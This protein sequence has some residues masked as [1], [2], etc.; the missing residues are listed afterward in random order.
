MVVLGLG[1]GATVKSGNHS[2]PPDG[3]AGG[4]SP[5]ASGG[6][7]SGGVT[8][9]GGAT[10]HGGALAAAG[11]PTADEAGAPATSEGGAG[12]GNPCAGVAA[13]CT[14]GEAVCDPR[15]G[16]LTACSE[17]GVPAPGADGPDCVRLLASD[18]ESNGVC[19]VR[20]QTAL[21]CWQG[22]VQPRLGQVQPSTQQLFL[23]DDYSE[24]M[25]GE[26]RLCAQLEGGAYS[27]L[28]TGAGCSHGAA[29]DDGF[30]AICAGQ[31][32][33]EG[34]SP[35]M[36]PPVLNPPLLDM[37]I[38][39]MDAIVLSPDDVRVDTDILPLP[40]AWQGAPTELHVDHQL[41]GCVRT[42][43]NELGCWL[44]PSG[45]IQNASWHGRYR[46]LVPTTLPKACVLDEQGQVSC[47]NILQDT[48]LEALGEPGMLDLV[49][50]MSEVCALSRVGKVSCWRDGAALDVPA[51]W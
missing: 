32:H 35:V 2:S 3:G 11:A 37:T 28:L 25:P 33:C 36:Q 38:T 5:P 39:D 21:E 24:L 40:A 26:L 49:A 16:K 43:D 30:C 44:S 27:C 4:L 29:G 46:K 17:C 14:P 9:G 31:L 51:G 15:L 42:S 6:V 10:G 8:S 7:A 18:K 20:G 50:S 22:S 34:N 12:L 19:V 47:G 1:C 41:A 48:E 23:P 45:P 13:W